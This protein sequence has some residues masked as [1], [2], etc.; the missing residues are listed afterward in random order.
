MKKLVFQVLTMIALFFA[1]WIG[2]SNVDWMTILKVEQVSQTTEERLGDLFW[3]IY[4]QSGAEIQDA[5]ITL[6]IDSLLNKITSSNGIDQSQVKL[7]IIESG[8]V[9]AFAL[10][11]RH[12]VIYSS[13][14]L[15]AE[16]E[17]ELCGVICHELAHMELNH[18]M[19]KLIKEIGLSVIISMTT[20]NSGTEIIKETAKLLSSTAYDRNLEKQADI[21]AIDYL[22][23]ADINPNSFAEFLYK[24]SDQEPKFSS[25]LSWIS[26]HP[27]SK[28]RAEYI[29]EYCDK[30]PI[31]FQPVL[32]EGTW[33][34]LQE[35]LNE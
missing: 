15:A 11:D 32:L 27:L 10:P 20:N 14:I 33:D 22:V 29:I 8:E 17:A 28:E 30:T 25:Y 34:Y 5:D 13:L 23:N 31:T 6:S 21:K 4:E 18:V 9:N 1:T 16:N 35:V 3:G 19:K 12:M 2:L 26:T 7:H 24:L